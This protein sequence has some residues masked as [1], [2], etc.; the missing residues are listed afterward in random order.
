MLSAVYIN[1]PDP[2]PKK[3]HRERRLVNTTFLTQLLYYLK[4]EGD[5][6]FVTDVLDYA[7]QVAELITP[8]PGYVNQ[9][10]TPF[11]FQLDGYP[12]SKYM[13]RFLSQ[14]LPVHFQHHQRRCDF[15]LDPQDLP[16]TEKGF[17]N[18]PQS[19]YGIM[20]YLTEHFPGTG[21]TIKESAEDFIVEE[22]PAYD[23]CGEGDHLYLRVEKQGMS[24]FAMIQRVASALN[25]KEKEIGY[26]GA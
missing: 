11:V 8:M 5:L 12:L 7:E 20:A 18:R 10:D 4:P 6:Y 26:A 22:I 2:W 23:P 15:T 13:R 16:V 19:G 24:T 14:G 17:R 1:C 21:G 25:V 3:R 9:L